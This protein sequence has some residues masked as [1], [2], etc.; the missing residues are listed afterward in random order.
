MQRLWESATLLVGLAAAVQ[1]LLVR[2]DHSFQP[3]YILRVSAENYTEACM[4]RYSVLVNGSLPGP[5]IRLREGETSW[6]RVYNDMS[7]ANTTIVS[8]SN[9][10]TEKESS[11]DILNSTGTV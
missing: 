10:L 6:I 8:T 9:L 2:H 1:G 4:D 5:E 3:D 11:A 7:D